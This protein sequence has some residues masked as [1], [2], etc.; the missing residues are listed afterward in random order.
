MH[1]L[2]YWA[3]CPEIQLLCEFP[4]EDEPQ[5]NDAYRH[6]PRLGVLNR[7]ECLELGGI[8]MLCLSA[9]CNENYIPEE[10][11]D[12]ACETRLSSLAYNLMQEDMYGNVEAILDLLDP[13]APEVLLALVVGIAD[14]ASSMVE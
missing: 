6:G 5:E 9:M 11:E 1:P 12:W 8:L 7:A 13:V 2:T 3:D 10:Q 4:N 14:C